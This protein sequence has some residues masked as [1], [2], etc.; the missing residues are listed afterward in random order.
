[1]TQVVSAGGAGL[2]HNRLTPSLKVAQVARAIAE[3]LITSSD[4]AE[5]AEKLGGCDP[6]WS[7][8][9]RSRMTLGTP[10]GH[11]G[12]R[13]L[14]RIARHRFSLADGFEGNA[15]TFRILTTTDVRGPAAVGLV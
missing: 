8:L 1:M 4:S 15:Q 9:P 2:L 13:T 7:K 5:L 12:E 11:L 6:T 14:D 10:L 3:R